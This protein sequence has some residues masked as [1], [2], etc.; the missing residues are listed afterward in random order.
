[1]SARPPW[2]STW[3]EDGGHHRKAGRPF[4]TITP[5]PFA[6]IDMFV[7]PTI[8]FGLLYG[9]AIL[10][11]SRRELLWLGVTAHPNAEW[12]ARQLTRRAVL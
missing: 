2:R 12:L 8:L 1:M 3:Q 9:L 10:R 4:F 6:A 5:T 7:V 11:Q